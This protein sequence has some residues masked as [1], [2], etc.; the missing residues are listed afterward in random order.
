MRNSF[1][2]GCKKSSQLNKKE[3]Q[4]QL[5]F[6]NIKFINLIEFFP[7]VLFHSGAILLPGHVP[8]RAGA[9]RARG[10]AEA[11]SRGAGRGQGAGG[12]PGPGRGA[13]RGRGAEASRRLGAGQGAGAMRRTTRSP[14]AGRGAPKTRGARAGAGN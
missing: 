1:F 13:R 8:S 10:P 3:I 6:T 2:R 11:P 4:F 14:G 7:F 9:D 12:T 5:Q